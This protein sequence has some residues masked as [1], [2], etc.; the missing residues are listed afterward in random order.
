MEARYTYRILVGKPF[1]KRQE[2]LKKKKA[3]LR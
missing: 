1:T 2:A 3:A